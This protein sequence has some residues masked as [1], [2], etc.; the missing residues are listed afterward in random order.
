MT[1]RKPLVVVSGAVQE[2]SGSD[3]IGAQPV[4][5]DLTT[6][7]GLT[8]T[9]D[10]VIQSVSSA[11][12][13]RTPAQLKATLALAK[14]D[15]GLGSVD[16]TSDATK[17]AAS[18]TLTNKTLTSPVINT[19]TGI[20]A[21]DVGAQPL[22]AD[23]TTIASLTATTDS[24]MQAK[25]GAWAARTLAQVKTDLAYTAVDIGAEKK[26]VPTASKT[27]AYTAVDGDLVMVD[28]TSGGITVTAPATAAGKEFGVKKTDSS[29]NIVTIARAGSDTIGA[30]AATSVQL[31]LQDQAIA[32]AANGT[33]WVQAENNLG[34]ANLD[35]RFQAADA[36]LTTIAGLTATTD[37]FMVA[38]SSAWASRTPAQAKTS[39]AIAV[40][41]VSGAA[42]LASPTFTGTV[43]TP[44]IITPP[45]TLTDAS[46][47]AI[48]ASLGNHFRLLTTSGVGA[49]RALG[50]PSNSTDGQ[51]ILIEVIQDGSGS[52]ALTY[53]AVYAWGTDVTV[54][55]LTTTAS[56]RDFLGF[57]YSSSATKWY[58][59]A[60]AR[61]Y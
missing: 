29:A 58:G 61:G 57:V 49:T 22:D 56:K 59:L 41:D 39:L 20:V 54:P 38:A 27:G 26:L 2:L 6:I 9:T 13:S 21:S 5:S 25:A 30:T 17:N 23:L 15:V 4:D 42:P 44:R 24:I 43:T 55:T 35:A 31:K 60:V 52:R 53:N 46:T 51:K 3:D 14:A 45:V 33:N 36:D 8:A 16:N 32:F 48:D 50:S 47:V 10:N 28:A 1:T 18:A 12:A 19:P 34:L 7:A 11:W 37:N 40:G